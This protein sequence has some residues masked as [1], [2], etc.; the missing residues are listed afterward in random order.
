[1]SSAVSCLQS[2]KT[3]SISFCGA[4]N[5]GEYPDDRG[6]GYPFNKTW[7]SRVHSTASVRDI[8]KNMPHIKLYDFKIK[9]YTRQ[10]NGTLT[11][12]PPSTIT[13]DN[14]IK[15]FFTDKD[16]QCMKEITQS[17]HPDHV[18]DLRDKKSVKYWAS[19]IYYECFLTDMPLD[20]DEK[21]IW[22]KEG[23]VADFKE[24]MVHGFK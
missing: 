24:W 6:M 23:R 3:Q 20:Y 14:K 9:R 17:T 10:Y 13:W 1:M 4:T 7:D 16:V 21:L 18:L 11:H 19:D 12:L 8:V 5:E 22:Q 2:G 15:N